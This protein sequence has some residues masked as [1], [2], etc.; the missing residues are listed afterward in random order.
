MALPLEDD[1][2]QDAQLIERAERLAERLLHRADRLRTRAERDR[3]AQVASMVSDPATRDFMIELT[4]EVLRIEDAGAAARRFRRVLEE[5]GLPAFAGP[6]DRAMLRAAGPAARA[7]PSVVV[8]QLHARVRRELGSIVLDVEER[9]LARAIRRRRAEGFQLN[10]NPLGEAVLGDDEAAARLATALELLGRPEVE[11]V[12]VKASAVCA[13]LDPMDAE[14]SVERIAEAFAVL[15]RSASERERPAFVNLDME[16][17]A[18]LWPTVHAFTTALE[19]PELQSF[20][21]GIVVQAY[22]PDSVGA[23]EHLAA[24]AQERVAAG[25]APVKVR[26]VKGANLAMERVDAELHGWAVAPFATKE[27]VD[28]NYKRLLDRA[29]APELAGALRVGVASHN[30]FDVAWALTLATEA[31]ALERVDVEMLHGMAEAEARAVVEHLRL[32]GGRKGRH[33]VVLYTPVVAAADFGAATAYL[34][35]RFDENTSP[36]NFLTHL[37]GLTTTGEAWADQRAR[38][39][40]A[41]RAR[42]A[43]PAVS[44]RG[45]GPENSAGQAFSNQ[46]DADPTQPSTRIAVASALSE[47]TAPDAVTA[48]IAGTEVTDRTTALPGVDPS[49]G[50]PLYTWQAVGESEVELA[51]AAGLAGAD[52][53]R[54]LSP[55]ERCDV[56]DAVAATMQSQRAET[57]AV[58][59]HDAGKTFHEA[60]PE[61]SEAVDFARY[62]GRCGMSLEP[63]FEPYRLVVVAAPWNFPYAIPAGGVFAA[64]A[65]GASVILKPAPETVLVARHLAEQCWAAGVPDDV[66]QLVLTDDDSAGTRLITHPDVDAVVLTGSSATAHLFRSWRPGL[67]LHAETSGKNAVVITA[68]ADLD[69]AIRDLVRSAFGHAGQKCSAASLA[70]VDGALLDSTRFLTRLA[71]AVRSLRVGAGYDAA[72]QMGPLVR[73][74]EGDLRRALTRLEPG[75]TWLVEPEQLSGN[76]LAWSPGVKVGVQPGSHFHLTECFGPVLG[77][78]RAAGLDEALELQNAVPFG[79]TAGLFSL[80]DGEVEEWLER[81]EAGNAYVNRHI[82]GAIVQRQPFGGWKQSAIG[83]GI[84]AGGPF[85]V[86]SLGRWPTPADDLVDRVGA[87]WEHWQAG[88]DRSGLVGEQNLL[89]LRALPR[90]VLLRT[91]P[92]TDPR[93]ILVARALAER[94]GVRLEISTVSESVADFLSRA[95]DFDRLRVF[96]DPSERLLVEAAQ[97]R[98]DLDLRPLQGSPEQELLCWA[99]EQA[100]SRT[101]HRHG[102]LRLPSS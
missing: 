95:G 39:E 67:N 31:Q 51:V 75:E 71:D 81:V 44:R 100:V 48:R 86:G 77:V 29:L 12:S 41:V 9:S 88:E 61:V 90:G 7:T 37:P 94:L 76:P 84:K 22:L 53:W 93:D 19:L 57:I 35:R 65:A 45:T 34:V 38:F 50:K 36:Q 40:A 92:A 11:Y 69:D 13:N 58:M 101:L 63:G 23:F 16:E 32:V 102:N 97:A 52:R 54:L 26:L 46:S 2:A 33:R 85:Y 5:R 15:C 17:Y 6:L 56:L 20:S 59:A 1:E 66:L 4:D 74:P 43:D 99:R 91:E 14:G 27:E 79:L 47:F 24:W 64:L 98:V 28:A 18:D 83:P 10:V 3:Q 72:T 60:D 42:H 73:E 87:L 21:A 68:A 89:R 30:L 82:T 96:G 78:M 62:Y 8:A 25:G 49:S 70:I 80:D 55:Q